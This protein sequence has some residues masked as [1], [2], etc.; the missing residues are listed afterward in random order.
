MPRF[1]S[2]PYCYLSDKSCG[3]RP[4]NWLLNPGGISWDLRLSTHLV[5]QFWF[6]LH[7]GAMMMHGPLLNFSRPFQTLID[8]PLI[9][10]IWSPTP[11]APWRYMSKGIFWPEPWVDENTK[12]SGFKDGVLDWSFWFKVYTVGRS[13]RATA[14]EAKINRN[15][16]KVLIIIS[17]LS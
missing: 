3:Y 1:H 8:W 7:C 13:F 6:F 15:K 11:P 16:A 4:G 5:G 14:E 9:F 2:L 10:Y 17:F 12:Y